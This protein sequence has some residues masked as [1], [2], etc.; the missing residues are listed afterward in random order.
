M[1][2]AVPR[3]GHDGP[4]TGE[5][6]TVRPP[7]GRREGR[8]AV[9][10]L[11]RLFTR[12]AAGIALLALCAVLVVAMIASFSMPRL[13]GTERL[14]GLDAR[15]EIVRDAHGI[16]RIFAKTP[17][18][19]WFALGYVH[20]MD[21]LWQMDVGRRLAQGRLSERFGAV[22]LP[23]DR[24][25][26]ALD[27]DG[28]AARSLDALSPESREVLAIYAAGVNARIARNE[29]EGQ[30][31]GAPEFYVFGGDIDSWTPADSLSI[32]KGMA[33]QLSR[34]AL[35]KEVKRGRMLLGLEPQQVHDLFPDYPGQGVGALP[36]IR[37]EGRDAPADPLFALGDLSDEAAAWASNAWA[38][39]GRHTASRAPLL[40][41]DPHLP[42]TAPGIWH[43][44]QVS[45]PGITLIGGSLPGLP[46]VVIGR[47]DRIAWGITA[48][49]IDD[50]DVFIEEVDP[51]DPTRYRTPDGWA[52]FETREETIRVSGAAPVE[53]TLRATRHGPV[54]PITVA[55][56]AAVTPRDHV[57]ALSWTALTDDDTSFDALRALNSAGTVAEALRA[58]D[59]Y[60]APALNLVVA[61]A[62]GVGMGV[63]GRVPLRRLTSRIQG[64]VPAPGWKDDDDWVGWVAPSSLP[65]TINPASGAV[66]NANNR[67]GNAA[68]PRHLSFD[69][70]APYRL[71]RILKQ[72]DARDTHSVESFR[73]LQM[74]SVSEMARA[75]APLVG[76]GLW[77]AAPGPEAHPLRTDA[78]LALRDWN[79][80]MSE[81]RGE[82]LIFVAWLDALVPRV[83]G[84]ELGALIEHYRGP[85]PLFLERV[86]RDI[87]EAG[88]WCDDIRTED[89]AETCAAMAAAALDDALT[90][91]AERYG[92]DMGDWRWGEAHHAVHRHSTLGDVGTT[93]MG[94][95][96]SLGTLVNIAH[97]T[98]GGDYTL[99]RGAMAHGG[100]EPYANVHAAGLR[101]VFDLADLDRSMFVVSTGASGHFLSEYYDNLAPLWRAGELVPMS[102]DRETIESGAV[103]TLVLAP[104]QDAEAP[105]LP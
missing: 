31:R 102:T 2:P 92:D 91:L 33:F 27:L 7:G 80:E 81:R 4:A 30:G 95:D 48:A 29:A 97:E 5:V 38:V 36:L 59:G 50:T 19:A 1:E 70:D 78:L 8:E 100:P 84:D 79:G 96:L 93:V 85:R 88:R 11:W 40:A 65:R 51:D 17:H 61:D 98:S 20:A 75:L 34:G 71:N 58:A 89:T 83:A 21:R 73:A 99:N 55:G 41:S 47:N 86:Y 94:V 60:I 10:G 16:P 66:A 52:A 25:M 76:E 3:G 23:T 43:P 6:K 68:F 18:D 87:D 37:T 104:D 22:A 105:M 56:L 103:G 28:H 90:G 57:P 39:D 9:G 62:R 53:M 13:S 69:W 77:D 15:I 82:P 64:R 24:L 45:G 54:M 42:L 101:A 44:V 14:A 35:A 72:L 74:D 26:R 12:V 63:V 46:A 67:V 32:L 49:E